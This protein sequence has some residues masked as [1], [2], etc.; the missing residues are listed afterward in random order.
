MLDRSLAP[1]FHRTT[2]LHLLNPKKVSL[3]NG[4]FMHVLQGGTQE[5]VRIELLAPAG[6]WSEP[7]TG[8]SHFTA[9]QLDKGT[10]S[11]NSYQLASAL[12]TQ[13]AHVEISA[14]N[15][16]ISISIYALTKN[17]L[18][19]V[20]LVVDMVL[21]PTF[22]EH[23]LTQSKAITLQNLLVNEEKTSFL[24]GKYFRNRIFGDHPYGKELDALAIQSITREML[25]AFHQKH[26]VNFHCIVTGYITDELIVQLAFLFGELPTSKSVHSASM[27]EDVPK[28]NH[29]VEKQGSIQS[30]IRYGRR[31]IKRD[32]ADFFDLLFLTHI[33][34]GYFGSRLMKNIREEKGLTYG[35]YASIQPLMHDA[36]MVI[37]ADVNKENRQ[38]TIDEIKVEIEKLILTPVSFEEL[39]AARNY[40]IGSLQT[41]V[42]N[43]FAHG[44]KF[45]TI[46][47]QDLSF[48]YYQ[49]M[50]NRVDEIT[51]DDLQR[52]ASLYLA[53]HSFTVVSVG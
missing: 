53:P 52:V 40:F 42:S 30:S 33:L 28:V 8:V 29:Y 21:N 23:E 50:I 9:S 36:F 19:V 2:T 26:L 51:P 13:G 32:H 34:G 41:E 1:S 11:K 12:E 7:L 24:A 31:C 18:E 27:P 49:R 47:L 4:R 38:L 37:G 45:K 39:E 46:L 15:D 3:S 10:A 20:K 5:V 25:V 44:D 16:F 17:V 6:K 43:V 35:I 22:P 48:D 14:G